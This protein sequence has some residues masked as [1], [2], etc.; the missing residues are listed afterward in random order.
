MSY[1][2]ALI[3]QDLCLYKR[4]FK[5][6]QKQRE[7]HEDIGRRWPTTSQEEDLEEQL[8]TPS[9]Q[10]R[11]LQY[12]EKIYFCCLSQVEKLFST[13]P[14]LCLPRRLGIDGIS[15]LSAA[16]CYFSPSK[17]IHLLRCSRQ[18]QQREERAHNP[19]QEKRRLKQQMIMNVAGQPKL[20]A[21]EGDSG[22]TPVLI[23]ELGKVLR[24][25]MKVGRWVRLKNRK[26]D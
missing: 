24:P 9:S 20:L 3:Q 22:K 8:L 2:W 11:S 6:T 13:K 17:L 19:Q 16:L 5:E 1:C 4:W 15:N 21:E 14:A 23:V 18:W 7:D 25:G 10:T 26:A 12:C